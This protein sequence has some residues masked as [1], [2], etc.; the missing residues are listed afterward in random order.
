[1]L[2][3]GEFAI[4]KEVGIPRGRLLPDSIK[5]LSNNEVQFLYSAGSSNLSSVRWY[6]SQG[7]NPNTYDENRTSPL[8]IAARQGSL[9]II[10][11]LLSSGACIN[12]ADCAGWT[13]LHVAAYYGRASAANELLN[14]G[15]DFALANRRGETPWD[16]AGN[17]STQQVFQ[18]FCQEKDS[19]LPTTKKPVDLSTLELASVLQNLRYEQTTPI[20]EES[21]SVANPLMWT[22]GT[23]AIN[24][25]LYSDP[26]SR[27]EEECI[28][29]FNSEPLKGFSFLIA[30]GCVKPN[31]TDIAKYL[32]VN[33][34]LNKFAVGVVLGENSWFHK[35]IANEYMK[36]IGFAGLHVVAA[37]RKVI[38]KC[39]LPREGTRLTNIL[40]AFA[41]SY[42]KENLHFGGADAIQGLCFSVI[43]LEVQRMEKKEFFNSAKGLLE[44]KDYPLGVLSWI[45]DEVARHPLFDEEESQDSPCFGGFDLEGLVYIHKKTLKIG[46][47]DDVI[48]FLS[49]NNN[50]PYAVAILRDCDVSDSWLQGSVAIKAQRG[51]IT[52]KFNKE[53]RVRVKR[54]SI[55]M[56]KSEEWRKW[57]EAIKANLSDDNEDN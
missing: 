54:E 20:I 32:L 48:I 39:S 14:H 3:G 52:A 18:R 55:L 53:G 22:A 56:F 25:Q 31:A 29:L 11:E 42:S 12:L 36:L 47:I 35:D 6:I 50:S 45:Y 30:L 13:P 8:H 43:M 27:M 38:N 19:E 10:K 33:K 9:Q 37:L 41:T 49:Q 28:N 57:V 44:G 51:I 40:S 24:N 1:M 34:K 23:Q 2:D 5:H 46:L 21:S 15:A 16:L 7:I 4:Y 26:S 17:D